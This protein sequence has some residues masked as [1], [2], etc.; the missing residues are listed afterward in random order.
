MREQPPLGQVHVFS[1][2]TPPNPSPK[3]T[4]LNNFLTVLP[5]PVEIADVISSAQSPE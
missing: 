4:Y 1:P 3:Q 2:L 5:Y